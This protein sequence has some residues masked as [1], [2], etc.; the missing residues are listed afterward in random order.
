MRWQLQ[1]QDTVGERHFVL[2]FGP[3]I[4]Q[5]VHGVLDRIQRFVRHRMKFRLAF[6]VAALLM[7]VMMLMVMMMLLRLQERLRQE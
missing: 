2:D 1:R 6:E 7:V 3:R 5:F 4:E